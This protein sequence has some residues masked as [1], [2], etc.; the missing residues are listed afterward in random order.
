[1]ATRKRLDRSIIIQAAAELADEDGLEAL[2]LQRVAERL[3]R[4]ISSLYSHIDSVDDLRTE[5]AILGI[6]EIGDEL[7][8][9]ALGRTQ[10]D[11]LIALAEAYRDYVRRHPGR[12][13]AH[14]RVGPSVDPHWKKASQ[15]TAEATRAVF[16]SFGLDEEETSHAHRVFSA[17]IRGFAITERL[18]LIP[19]VDADST[20]RQLTLL[21]I[22]AL[23]H[24]HWPDRSVD[25]RR[26]WVVL[27]TANDEDSSEV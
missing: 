8:A 15:R 9:A 13:D 24:R 14:L 27:R 10:A 5:I 2:T 11:A 20:F 21:F 16:R 7:W 4:N 6:R 23:E 22:N 1:V 17:T 25:L 12:Y 19:E 26:E 3:G 18:D